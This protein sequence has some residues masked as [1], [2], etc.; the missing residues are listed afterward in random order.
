MHVDV[1]NF[2]PRRHSVRQVQVYTFTPDIRVPNGLLD[3]HRDPE[4][5]QANRFV[6]F[7]HVSGVLPGHD[8]NMS[9][10]D[11]KD[12][13]KSED[14]VILVDDAGGSFTS[15]NVTKYTGAHIVR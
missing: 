11:W 6:H 14:G 9:E 3:T 4:Q 1:V 7:S 15:R 2:L 10:I 5:T 13:H 8:Q 12:I